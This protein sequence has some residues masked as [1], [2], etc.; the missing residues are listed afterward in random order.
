MKPFYHITRK[1]RLDDILGSDT[2]P[3]KGLKPR[4][5]NGKEGYGKDIGDPNYVCIFTVRDLDQ[6]LRETTNDLTEEGIEM[7]V[8]KVDLPPEHP[9]ERDYDKILYLIRFDDEK[10]QE[11]YG[12][13]KLDTS[14]NF[15]KTFGIKF[16]GD[17]NEENLKK[18]F[19]MIPEDVYDQMLG[20]YRTLLTI[21]A[22]RLSLVQHITS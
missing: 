6:F 13:N 2:K 14:S 5:E 8:L 9:L 1:E 19:D 16:Q 7:S 20:N 11:I 3:G 17:V 10:A 12:A 15:F 21:T 4:I 18:H 22:E